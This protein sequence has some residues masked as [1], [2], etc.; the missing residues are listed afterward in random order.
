MTKTD[1][2]PLDAKTGGN[3]ITEQL[4]DGTVYAR[5]EMSWIG[6][7]NGLAYEGGL[8]FPNIQLIPGELVLSARLRLTFA[9][10]S[11]H[12]QARYKAWPQKNAPLGWNIRAALSDASPF[13]FNTSGP[14]T[15][16]SWSLE[17]KANIGAFDLTRRQ[18][19]RTTIHTGLLPP[20][21]RATWI[22]PNLATVMDEVV[23]REGWKFGNAM[24]FKVSPESMVPHAHNQCCDYVG[25]CELC[26]DHLHVPDAVRMYTTSLFFL[27]SS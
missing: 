17:A 5:S 12:L 9:E 16:S 4:R 7:M 6:R 11:P 14:Y 3:D 19:T 8:R 24:V 10:E 18:Y 27:S 22:S 20:S 13:G 25:V 2:G 21:V 1:V 23:N 26:R 15:P